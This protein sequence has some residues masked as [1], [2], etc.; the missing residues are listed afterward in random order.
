MAFAPEK[1]CKN[2]KSNNV[3]AGFT[4]IEALVTLVIL[5][6]LAIFAI[7][8]FSVW[9][10]NYRLSNAAKELY[11]NMSLAKLG[12]IKQNKTWAVVFDPSVSP[13]RYFICSD[14]G[15][16]GT[17]D[18]P[19]AMGGDDVAVKTVLLSDYGGQVDFGHAGATAP[20]GGGS[21]PADEISYASN[22]ATFNA[23]G[24]GTA[25]YVFL[26]NQE[27]KTYAIGS[28]NSGIIMLKKW[29]GSSWQDQ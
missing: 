25:G 4:L 13:G 12:A 26:A 27:G 23:T 14:D 7:P 22:V 17:W 6:I 3:V 20:P 29:D 10:P 9:I 11:S 21:F 16:N 5:G 8:A 28:L 18:G 1:I 24:F 15:A 2:V 19:P